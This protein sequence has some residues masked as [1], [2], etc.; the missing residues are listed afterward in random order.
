MSVSKKI[1]EILNS[2]SQYIGSETTSGDLALLLFVA[3]AVLVGLMALVMLFSK[4]SS[5]QVSGG[6]DD[7]MDRAKALAGKLERFEMNAN[8]SQ[9]ELFREISFLKDRTTALEAQVARL[10]QKAGI[11]PEEVESDTLATAT[12]SV[13]LDE[14]QPETQPEQG[15]PVADAHGVDEELSVSAPVEEIKDDRAEA[16]EQK[17]KSTRSGIFQKL[18][19]IFVSSPTIDA[20]TVDE[21]EALLVSSDLGV[22][23]TRS[24]IQ[25]LKEDISGGTEITQDVLID[26]LKSNVHRIFQDSTEESCAIVPGKRDGQP[27]VIMMVGVNGVGKT[28]TTAKLASR[29]KEDGSRVLM[30]AADTFRAAATEQL[31]EWGQRID[32]PVVSGAENAKPATVVFEAMERA[33]QENSDVVIIDTAGRLHTKSNLME[34]LEGIRNVVRRHVP[35]APHEVVLVVDGSTGQNALSQAREF[36]ES[37]SLTGLVVTKLDGTPKGGI[38]VAIKSE[39]GL[40]VRYIGVGES[41]ADLRL[42]N[43]SEFID[44]LFDGDVNTALEAP[45][46]HGRRRRR[47]REEAAVA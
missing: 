16:L 23:M 47:R 28:T 44:A 9:T 6:E 45:S 41:S 21:L 22:A 35:G 42:F 4:K 40:P 31:K 25:D 13:K 14:P 12:G 39:L 43:S 26:N 34:E 37:V 29:W 20:S 5:R 36:N 10:Q 2:I 11:E 15:E 19:S 33:R 3:L 18:R 7:S 24:L 30:V 27:L 38:V 46:A 32:V 17:L 8:A 1:A